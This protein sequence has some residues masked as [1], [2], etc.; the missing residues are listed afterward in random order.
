MRPAH[1]L[2]GHLTVSLAIDTASDRR[3][4]RSCLI[5]PISKRK[6]PMPSANFQNYDRTLRRFHMMHLV[7]QL[8]TERQG[9]FKASIVLNGRTGL[10]LPTEAKLSAARRPAVS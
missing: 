10:P 1:Y 7:E 8:E 5:N 2:F 3:W 4:Q 9:G 6:R